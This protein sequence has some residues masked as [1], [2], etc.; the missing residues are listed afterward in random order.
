L[1]GVD[2]TFEP[3]N[4]SVLTGANGSGK[5]TLLGIL[6][7]LTRPTSGTVRHGDGADVSA[8]RARLGWV[9]HDTLA[10]GDLSGRENIILAARVHGL[11]PNVALAEAEERFSLASFVDRLVRTYSRGQRQRVALARALVHH[12]SLLLLDEPTAGLDAS[13]TA[14]LVAVVK[15]EARRGATIILSTHE[16]GVAAELGGRVFLLER[17]AIRQQAAA[18]LDERIQS[19]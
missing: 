18:V 5:S 10:Y 7:T 8:V 1:S 16:P 6:G 19:S 2:A 14:R 17:G 13:S 3:G 4:V 9:G 11:D 15:E 12:P